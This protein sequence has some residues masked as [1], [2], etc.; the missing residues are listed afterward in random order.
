MRNDK[1]YN[2]IK[3]HH[4]NFLKTIINNLTI[5]KHLNYI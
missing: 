2:K 5:N 1:K 3:T 4:M